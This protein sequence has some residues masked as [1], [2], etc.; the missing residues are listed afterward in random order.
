M[1]ANERILSNE[2]T[3]KQTDVITLPLTVGGYNSLISVS[4]I[5]PYIR[6]RLTTL[7][8]LGALLRV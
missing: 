1:T 7:E 3:N 5:T 4:F 2:P 8:Y 6:S